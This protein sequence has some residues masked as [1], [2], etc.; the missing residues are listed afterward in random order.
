MVPMAV[1]ASLA[2]EQAVRLEPIHVVP[3]GDLREH[4]DSPTCWCKPE[5]DPDEPRVLIHHSM[6]RREEYEAGRRPS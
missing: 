6:D 2:V 1:V 5:P 4:E 3:M